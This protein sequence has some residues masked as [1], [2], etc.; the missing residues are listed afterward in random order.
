MNEFKIELNIG[1]FATYVGLTVSGYDLADKNDKDIAE[2]YNSIMD[3]DCPQNV[4]DY[5]AYARTNKNEV[6]PYW[7]RSSI[8]SSA[9]FFVSTKDASRYDSFDDFILFQRSVGNVS[10]EEF[11]DEVTNWLKKLPSFIDSIMRNNAFDE[12][13]NNY[14]RIIS[15]RTENYIQ[16][17]E[18]VDK[19]IN[20]FC[21]DSQLISPNIVFSPNLLQSPYIA[22]SVTRRNTIIII[23]TSPDVLSLL[24]EFLHS[25]IKPLRDCFKVYIRKYDFELM[26]DITKMSFHGHMWNESK[27]SMINALEESFVRG[28]SIAMTVQLSNFG[29]VADYMLSEVDTGFKLVPII[30]QFAEHHM[31]NSNNVSDFITRVL[32][33][34]VRK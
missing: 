2:L 21:A 31:P 26:A 10:Q 27:E 12:L 32:D 6:N 28:L 8:L 18:K 29:Q 14:Q 15:I 9:C 17:L 13:W 11:D 24:H 33:H 19:A 22:D 5:F 1:L 3:I 20:N 30:A 4:V 23:K 16:V 34:H 7:P 25:V